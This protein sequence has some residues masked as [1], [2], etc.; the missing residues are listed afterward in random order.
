M[1]IV[2]APGAIGLQLPRTGV[3][4]NA[5]V[6]IGEQALFHVAVG[7]WKTDFDTPENVSVHPVGAAAI[8]FL[9]AIGMEVVDPGMFQEATDD[10]LDP[11]IF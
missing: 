2:S 5:E 9:L 7:D 11:Y 6:Q 8:N 3:V 4:L 10:R 1:R